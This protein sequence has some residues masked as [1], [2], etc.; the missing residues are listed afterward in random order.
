MLNSLNHPRTFFAVNSEP[1]SGRSRA[2]AG[3]P[4]RRA[5]RTAP[6]AAPRRGRCSD[7]C[8]QAEIPYEQIWNPNVS[9]ASL[10]VHRARAG[11]EAMI[12]STP[13][14]EIATRKA[15]CQILTP[16]FMWRASPIRRGSSEGTGWLRQ[17]ITLLAP[18]VGLIWP[19][20]PVL[21]TIGILRFS[22]RRCRC[23]CRCR[24][25]R[26]RGRRGSGFIS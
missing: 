10:L 20:L 19:P 15:R 25:R 9:P 21:L 26:C 24:C 1:L 16:L 22:R 8:P 2:S 5:E 6:S 17:V 12:H 7:A 11:S 23:R 13:T 18:L 3:S 14:R 4:G